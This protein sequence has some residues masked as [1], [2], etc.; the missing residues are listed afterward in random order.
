MNEE[1]VK[2]KA[3]TFF[4]HKIEVHITQNDGAWKNG[5]IKK[6]FDTYLMLDERIE[7]EMPIFFTEIKNMVKFT[8]KNK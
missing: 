5:K 4:D 2:L 7:G 3:K 6:I 1:N 8:Q